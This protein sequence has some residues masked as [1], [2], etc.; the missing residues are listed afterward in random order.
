MQ[1]CSVGVGST[2]A[3]SVANRAK[4]SSH[5]EP[6][7]LLQKKHKSLAQMPLERWKRAQRE[8]EVATNNADKAQEMDVAC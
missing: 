7:R 6:K 8:Q 1:Q 3:S 4:H 5:A 2:A